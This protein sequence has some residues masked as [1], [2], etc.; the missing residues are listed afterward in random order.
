MLL[1]EVS[2][3]PL[4]KPF[5][6]PSGPKKFAVYVKNDKG[7]VVKVTF[8]DSTGLS[9]KRDQKERRDAFRARH[10]CSDPGP[11]WK[12]RYWSC[13]MWQ[14]ST[15]VSDVLKED[16]QLQEMGSE[17]RTLAKKSG[18]VLASEF[19][20]W[21]KDKYREQRPTFKAYLKDL[22]QSPKWRDDWFGKFMNAVEDEFD[23]HIKKASK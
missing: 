8:G 6:T 2:T 14:P 11:K 7:N 9:I 18:S 12:A 21:A 17:E 20:A 5:R 23:R 19:Q 3:P 15:T 1:Q 4:N 10:N 22:A 16:R 13:K